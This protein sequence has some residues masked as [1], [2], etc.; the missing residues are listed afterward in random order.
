MTF[1]VFVPYSQLEIDIIE[2]L[3]GTLQEFYPTI[4]ELKEDY[5]ES[6]YT[7]ITIDGVML[8]LNDNFWL[9]LDDISIN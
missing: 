7:K 1:E 5:P 4:N 3:G 6:D 9:S 8:E 2:N